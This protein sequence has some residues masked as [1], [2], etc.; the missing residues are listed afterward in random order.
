MLADGMAPRRSGDDVQRRSNDAFLQERLR[1]EWS[2]A[3]LA[4]WA[5]QLLTKW[6]FAASCDAEQIRRI[7]KNGVVPS[8]PGPEAFCA[9]FELPP[10]QLG[11]PASPAVL[12]RY[13]ASAEDNSMDEGRRAA[14]KGI[15]AILAAPLLDP[16]VQPL[17]RIAEMSLSMAADGAEG[18][19]ANLGHG[20]STEPPERLRRRLTELT[21]LC[22][23]MADVSPGQYAHR[24][25]DV[26]GWSAGL[27]ANALFDVGDIGA[28][29]TTILLALSYGE[30]TGDTRLIAY[31]RD[32][33]AMMARESGDHLKA[34]EHIE[35]GLL[36]A[37][38]CTAIRVR[39]LSARAQL[40]AQIG[41]RPEALADLRRHND[42]QMRLP[43]EE[44]GEGSFKVMSGSVDSTAGPV[45]LLLGDLDAAC[46][47]QERTLVSGRQ[48]MSE[49]RPTRLAL[50]QI[51]LATIHLRSGRPDEAVSVARPALKSAFFVLPAQRRLQAFTTELLERHPTLPEAC[52]FVEEYRALSV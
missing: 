25:R 40:H 21:T 9:L 2:R 24:F 46:R 15:S 41:R 13:D 14:L 30:R 8:H 12:R 31:V 10:V 47:A 48:Q 5:N 42:E 6:G 1:R 18:L 19:L 26:A 49:Q 27:L 3:Q 34:L 45:L 37:P 28:A 20:Y 35:L 23:A 51:N 50:R 29:D 32:R 7:E 36:A 4:D 38:S 33:Q 52:Q 44:L 22:G 39:L 11:F 17:R 43:R 16:A